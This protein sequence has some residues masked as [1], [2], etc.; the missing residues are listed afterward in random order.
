MT[1]LITLFTVGSVKTPWIT[2]GCTQYLDRMSID[3]VEVPA[4]KQRDPQ[5][6]VQE[7]STFLLKRLEKVD[8][9]IW[10]LDE[11]GEGF[12]SQ[13]FAEVLG[14][15]SDHGI[16][17]AFV[18]GGAYGLHDAIR[19]KAHRCIRLSDM[20]FPHELCR[21]F[22]LEQLYRANQIQKGSGYHH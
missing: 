12:T 9:E 13:G 1:S 19:A 16:C 7:E 5:K 17:I 2:E 11:T 14:Q 4:S 8:G 18:L 15:K 21:L 20:T 6:Q 3:V 22:F 10:V